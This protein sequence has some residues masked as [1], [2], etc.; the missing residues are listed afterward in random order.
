MGP[1]FDSALLAALGLAIV[2]GLVAV[3]LAILSISLLR[4]ALSRLVGHLRELRRHALVGSLPQESEPG[5]A[6]L[7]LEINALVE[8]LRSRLRDLE[9]QR[10]DLAGL[11]AG[12][13]DL[14]LVGADADWGVTFFSRGAVLMLGWAPEEIA[15]RHV[16][17]LFADRE[18]ERLLPKLSRRSLREAGLAEDVRLRRRDGSAFPAHLSVA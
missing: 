7:T 5:L 11:A 13:P 9:R 1:S 4:R 16:E 8:D 15:G 17:S 12:P 14:A 2:A 10:A 18:W 6:S 3:A